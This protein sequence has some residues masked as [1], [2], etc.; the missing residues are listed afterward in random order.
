MSW[1]SSGRTSRQPAPSDRRGFDIHGY[2]AGGGLIPKLRRFA[3][4]NGIENIVTL[5]GPYPSGQLDDILVLLN[6][7]VLPSRSEGLPLVLLEAM[8]RGVPIVATDAG[9]TAEFG[10]DNP[11]V[12]ITPIDWDAFVKGLSEMAA[13][14]AGGQDRFSSLAS[15]DRGAIRIRHGCSPMAVR[16]SRP[17]DSSALETAG[18]NVDR[19]VRNGGWIHRPA[20]QYP[21]ASDSAPVARDAAEYFAIE[22]GYSACGEFAGRFSTIAIGGG[23]DSRRAA[24]TAGCRQISPKCRNAC[25]MPSTGSAAFP[26]FEHRQGIGL[27]FKVTVGSRDFPDGIGHR[28]DAT[29]RNDQAVLL[30]PN[31]LHRRPHH[32]RGD[33]GKLAS[34]RLVDHQRHGS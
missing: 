17:R 29:G 21:P 14:L 10:R 16:V 19:V 2:D 1:L 9:G 31:Q 30:V 32:G 33:D 20:V 6:V 8:Q 23:A 12:R 28:F 15:L 3:S 5:H 13:L 34:D 11:D 27:H 18:N 4:E 22:R 25:L 24:T 7:V 26:G